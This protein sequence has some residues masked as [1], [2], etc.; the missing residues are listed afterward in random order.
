MG[1][2]NNMQ[3]HKIEKCPKST[4]PT[5]Y[6][7]HTAHKTL[8]TQQIV[9][10]IADRCAVIL[11]PPAFWEQR[12]REVAFYILYTEYIYSLVQIVITSFPPTSRCMY[13]KYHCRR[14]VKSCWTAV[15]FARQQLCLYHLH[16]MLWPLSAKLRGMEYV[17]GQVQAIWRVVQLNKPVCQLGVRVLE[18]PCQVQNTPDHGSAHAQHK[19]QLSSWRLYQGNPG[20]KPPGKQQ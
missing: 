18:H 7:L 1:T 2:A 8:C 6:T 11:V 20:R 5:V 17:V 16:Q 3:L 4:H 14:I 12:R 13:C 15:C 10:H 9:P 19:F